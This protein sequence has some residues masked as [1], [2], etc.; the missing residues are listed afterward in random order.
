ME[1]EADQQWQTVK[2][3][4]KQGT[5]NNQIWPDIATATN[6]R[7][8][9]NN[10]LITFFFTNFPENFGAKAMFNAFQH[11]GNI[12]EVVIPIK[13]DRRGRRFGFARFKRVLDSR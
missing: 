11:Y 6:Y 7:K 4:N 10:D 12:M 3:R 5:K 8:D 1:E 9:N 2:R 13:R